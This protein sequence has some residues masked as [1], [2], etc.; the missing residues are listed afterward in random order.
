VFIGIEVLGPFV[1]RPASWLLGA[2]LAASTTTGKLSQENA[3]RN[4]SRTA[5]TAA[6]LMVGVALVSLT[7]IVA[8]SMK[9]SSNSIINSAVRADFVVS[10]GTVG[11]T[12]GFSPAIER[13]LNALPQVSTTAGI[14]SGVVKIYGKVT[15]VTASDPV[16]ADALF[17]MRVTQGR[18]ANM[19]ASGIAVSTQVA[20]SQHLR[21][22]SQVAVTFPTTGTK[23]FTVQV[24]YSVR[25]L[26]G[27]YVLPL[28]AA[29]ANFP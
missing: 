3:M 29:E 1:A 21:M 17:D 12:S 14:R 20:N 9:A 16:K 28:A 6:A 22:G 25:A 11:G 13:S 8:S 7:T 5:A 23:I 19:T 2:R 24:I 15:S 10:G 27:D 26:A 18:L 4:P